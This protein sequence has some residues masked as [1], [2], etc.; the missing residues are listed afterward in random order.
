MI[1]KSITTARRRFAA[2]S[3]VVGGSL[4]A[5]SG[6]LQATDLN[7]TEDAVKTP[8]Q[9]V[10][11]ALFAAGIVLVIPVLRELAGFVTSRA[12]FA[13]I[14]LAAGQAGVAIASTVSNIRGVDASWFPAVAVAANLAWI[15]GTITLAVAL[16]RS[17]RVPRLLA[18][19]LVA[20]Y[21][22]TIPLGSH[23]GCILSGCYFLACGYLLAN[24]ALERRTLQ[25]ATP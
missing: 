24:S 4:L 8:A 1:S 21:V 19:G 22:G 6:A 17:G 12:R 16:Y 2:G 10:T 14:P 23:G 15:V 7:W 13:W 18:L 25:P 20:A 9:H 3:A 5:V 11:M